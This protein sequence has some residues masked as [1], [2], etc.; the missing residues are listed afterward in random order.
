[1]NRLFVLLFI[2]FLLV[3]TSCSCFVKEPVCG[4]NSKTYYNSCLARFSGVD[5][6]LGECRP[7]IECET[8]TKNVRN[9]PPVYN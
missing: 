1:M 6:V 9:F 3:L 5:S 2:L 4:A 8:C 7:S